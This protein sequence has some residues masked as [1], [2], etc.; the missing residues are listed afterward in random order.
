[1]AQR[2]FEK[3]EPSDGRWEIYADQKKDY[4]RVEG[5]DADLHLPL[6]TGRS[7]EECVGR[8]LQ[9]LLRRAGRELSAAWH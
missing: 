5:F 6:D 4:D 7:L 9:H 8:I 3:N 2:A 1:M